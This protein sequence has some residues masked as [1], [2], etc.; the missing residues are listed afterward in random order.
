M[1][2]LAL[3]DPG[4]NHVLAAAISTSASVIVTDNIKDFP[5]ELLSPHG[6]EVRSTDDFIADRIELDPVEA[7]LA[8]KRRRERLKSPNLDV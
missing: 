4:D 5:V 2:R 8:L 1:S 3:P 7:I 6:V